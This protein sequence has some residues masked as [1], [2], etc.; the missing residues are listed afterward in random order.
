LRVAPHAN[1]VTNCRRSAVTRTFNR[2]TLR[3]NQVSTAAATLAPKYRLGAAARLALL[4]GVFFAEK[5]FLN[6]FIDFDRA[7]SAHGIGAIVRVAQH[8]GFRLFVAL[9][10]AVALFTY[11]RGSLNNL[12]VAASIR[13]APLRGGLAIGHF[14][15]VAALAPLSYL[16]YRDTGTDLTFALVA[17][18]WTLIA[19]AAALAAVAAMAPLSLWLG[20]ARSLGLIWPYA[21]LAAVVGTGAM[22]LAQK[23]WG[24]TAA[25]TFELVRHLL[26]P[27]L[28]TLHADS[29]TLVLSTDRFAVQI[30]E[31][32]SGLEGVGLMLA[33]SGAWLLYFR[34]EYIFPRAL[35][36]IPAGLAAIFTLNVFRIAALI[37]IGNAGFPDVAIYG[38]HSQAGWIAF[39]AVACGLVLVSRRSAWLNRTA[40]SAETLPATNNPT[41]TYLMPLLAILAAGTLSRA[42]SSDFEFFYPLRL[43]AGVAAIVVYRHKLAALDWRCSWRG[44]A[45]GALVFVLWSAA[46]HFQLPAGVIPGK[47]LSMPPALRALWIVSRVAASVLLVPI[48]EE[49]AYRG[50][51]MRRFMNADFDQVPFAQVHWPAMLATA[52]VFGL[53]HGALWAP[54][55]VAG[56]AFGLLVV[57]RG[58]LGEAVAA[59]ATANALIAVSVLAA[60]QWQLW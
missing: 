19:T 18:V 11:V 1:R 8:W 33:F 25:F 31:V 29:A 45:V 38:F 41:A 3:V 60:G 12:A 22:Q 17:V 37:L 20:A 39:I 57:R 56:L 55:I 32:C 34:R 36:L 44:P 48:A 14:I 42:I 23:L 58:T 4:G 35:L 9:A 52:V 6:G 54:G 53:A 15:L 50:Y 28:P 47:L 2:Y 13:A 26:A 51:L 46:A 43:L 40:S 59:H 49:L 10:A 24:P 7:Q 5:I 27:I 21:A 16:L 30:A